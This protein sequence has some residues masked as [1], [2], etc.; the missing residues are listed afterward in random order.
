MGLWKDSK[1]TRQLKSDTAVCLRFEV[2][3]KILGGHLVWNGPAVC[4]LPSLFVLADSK[5]AM[6][7]DVW[8]SSRGDGVWN[9][10]FMRSFNDWELDSVLN[11]IIL[12]NNTIVNHLERDSPFWKGRKMVC[13]LLN[14]TTRFWK[15][16]I[17][18]KGL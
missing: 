4:D 13:T 12:I 3:G 15:A 14:Q 17:P 18:G 5:G 10:R 16:V 6:V 7:A 1:E 2:Q 8:D 11:F 9:P